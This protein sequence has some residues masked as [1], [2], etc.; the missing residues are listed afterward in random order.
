MHKFL[1]VIVKR[2]VSTIRLQSWGLIGCIHNEIYGKSTTGFHKP[3]PQYTE[4]YCKKANK[5]LCCLKKMN[6]EMDLSETRVLLQGVVNI[7]EDGLKSKTWDIHGMP[8]FITTTHREGC[9]M[10]EAYALHIVEASKA[11][12]E[13]IPSREVEKA[14]QI[15]WPN[16]VRHIEDEASSESDKKVKWYSD[17]HDNLT[18]DIRTAEN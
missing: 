14:F 13:E 4:V 3:P 17:H 7:F 18:D 1:Q 12:T 8:Q 6:P 2:L 15:A 11:S 10:C 16:I 5:Q 9:D